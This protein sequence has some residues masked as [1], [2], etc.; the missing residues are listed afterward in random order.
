MNFEWDE[1]KNHINKK[2]HKVSFEVASRV[3]FDPECITLYDE[4]HSSEF[5]DRYVAI[6]IVNEVLYVVY[7]EKCDAIRIISARK[8]SPQERR[9]YYDKKSLY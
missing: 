9:T 8:A 3:F 2:K 7:T 4:E 5:E 6:G 1:N